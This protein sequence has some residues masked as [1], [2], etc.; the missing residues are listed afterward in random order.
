[1]LFE[2]SFLYLNFRK[3]NYVVPIHFRIKF[4]HK[5][6]MLEN[7]ACLLKNKYSF[8]V[9]LVEVLIPRLLFVIFLSVKSM[10]IFLKEI[11]S[12]YVFDIYIFFNF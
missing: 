9:S 3:T 6:N 2:K 1:M 5:I 8:N 7:F 4:E 10:L 11:M 12:A